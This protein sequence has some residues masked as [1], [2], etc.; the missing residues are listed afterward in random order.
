MADLTFDIGFRGLSGGLDPE[1]RVRVDAA[2]EAAGQLAETVE[3]MTALRTGAAVDRARAEE[4]ADRIVTA[5]GLLPLAVRVAGLR[6]AVLRHMPLT[7]YAA[8]LAEPA[9]TLDE[10]AAGDVAVRP[11]LAASWRDLSRPDQDTLL[12]LAELPRGVPF[13]AA[14]VARPPSLSRRRPVSTGRPP[15]SSYSRRNTWCAGWEV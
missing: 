7:E 3:A 2:I 12:R 5:G 8:R 13:T 15:T 10:L 11:G 6:L 14:Q 9:A 4:A 1:D